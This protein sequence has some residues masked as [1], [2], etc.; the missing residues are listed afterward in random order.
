M[1]ARPMGAYFQGALTIE[2][3]LFMDVYSTQIAGR[4]LKIR[5]DQF[6]EQFFLY[7]SGQKYH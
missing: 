1:T 5:Q 3:R 2:V 4:K 7:I 6:L